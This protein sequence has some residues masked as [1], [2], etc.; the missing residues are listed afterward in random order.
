MSLSGITVRDMVIIII[1]IIIIITPFRIRNTV[2]LSSTLEPNL[3]I[4]I[5]I[6]IYISRK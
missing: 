2:F 6:Y 3:V 5:Y 4:Y 1:I